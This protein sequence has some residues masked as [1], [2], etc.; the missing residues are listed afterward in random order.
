MPTSIV[1]TDGL[2]LVTVAAPGAAAAATSLP[3]QALVAALASG[4]VLTFASGH[5]AT[6]TAAA[7]VGAT[8]LVVSAL[9]NAMSAG[10]TASSPITLTNGKAT[11][12]DRFSGWMT[13]TTP[14]GDSAERQSDGA[15]SM[16]I[17]RTDYTAAFDL[18]QIPVAKVNGERL[19]DYADRLIA[20]LLQGGTCSVNTGDVE[21]NSYATCGLAPG[22]TP[23]LTLT[24]R[25][26]LEYT[27]H[28]ALL[29]LAASPTRMVCHY[30]T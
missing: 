24:D 7:A 15:R 23:G 3:V 27:L 16:F 28:L 26:N 9:A 29:N 14:I 12:G 1:F 30:L 10:D 22:E 18:A 20:W 8:S 25:V 2:T 17:Y 19:V 6:L 11:P 13:K 21:A 5:T 4:T